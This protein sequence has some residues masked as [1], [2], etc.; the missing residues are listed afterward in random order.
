[1]RE[2]LRYL[3]STGKT[4]IVSSHI[5][6]EVQQ[7]AD[8]IGIIDRGRLVREGDLETLLAESGHVR[9]RVS[10]TEMTRAAEVLRPLAG[11]RPL[12]GIDNGPQ[13]GWFTVAVQP[14]HAGEVN[15]RL[16]EAGIFASA[17]EAGSDLESLFLQLTVGA[18]LT[19]AG[20]QIPAQALAVPPPP[21]PGAPHPE[22]TAAPRPPEERPGPPA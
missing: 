9:V 2:T 3:T 6:P 5:L 18:A 20:P 4:V 17:L 11:D 21:L 10:P 8:V 13:A 15:R 14:S 19:I 16:A 7:L 22:V 12:Y 1:M